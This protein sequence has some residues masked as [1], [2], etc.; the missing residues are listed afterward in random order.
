MKNLFTLTLLLAFLLLS[1]GLSAQTT[2]QGSLSDGDNGDP[3]IGASVT[4]KGTF[5]GTLTDNDGSF[6]LTTSKAPP[7][8]L[9]FSYAGY[10]MQE[11]QVV[12][13]AEKFDIR[14][15]PGLAME[16]VTVVGSRT[17]LR[18]NLEK[19]VP[20][21]LIG[22][23]QLQHSAQANVTQ[24]LQYTAPSFHSTPQTIS[25]GTDHIDPAALRGLGPDQTLVLINGKRRH[26]SSLLNV[27][28]TVG[29]G[30]VGT[31]LNSIPASAIDRI[32]VLRDGAAAQ[33]GSDA[34]AGVINIILKEKP[35]FASVNLQTGFS[36]PNAFGGPDGGNV[37]SELI[38]TYNNDGGMYQLS[39]NVGFGLGKNGGFLNATI[40]HSDRS[41][42]NRSG[43]YTGSIYPD[44][45]DN[46]KSEDAFFQQVRDEYDFADR[47]VMQI[48]NSAVT[49]TG[50]ML[51][52]NLPVN[53]KG[54]ELY[55]TLGLNIRNGLARGF[56]RFPSTQARVVPQIY[57]DGFSPAIDSD[58]NDQSVTVGLR[59]NIGEWK[60]D[61]SHTYGKNAFDFTIKNSINA[62]LGASSP[63]EAYAGGFSYAQNTSNVDFTREVEVG[64][65]LNIG[66]G[67]EFRNENYQIFNGEEASYVAGGVENEWPIDG[68]TSLVGGAAGIQVFPGFQPQNALDENRTNI[69]FYTELDFEFTDAFV[70]TTAGRFENYSDFGS[71]L[72]W[73]LASRYKLSSQYGVRGSISTGFRAPSLHQVYFNNLSTQFI[74]DPLTGD[75]VPVQVGTF[76]N[77]S[78]V[79]K[80]FGIADLKAETS[81]NYS[82]GFTGRVNDNF[83]FTIDGYIIDIKDRI[84]ISGRFSPDEQL[85][86][87]TFARDI[88]TP[89]GAGAAQFFTNAVSTRTKGLD[90]VGSYR[91]P[92]DN[93]DLTLTFAGNFTDT[94]VD[95]KDGVPVINTPPLLEGKENVLFNREEV[96]RIE[97]AQPNSK[98]SLSGLY[99]IGKFSA[100]LRLTRFGKITYIH[101]ADGGDPSE[102]PT[103]SF[104]GE[105][106]SRDQVFGAKIVPDLEVAYKI[107]DNVQ[108]TLGAHNFTNTY[109]DMHQHSSNVSSG[110]FLFSRRVQQFGVRGMFLYTK[111]GLTF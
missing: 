105:K 17:R 59:S 82:L 9:E 53:D 76:N 52:A 107:T 101:P 4:I 80:A 65:P 84:V 37:P 102:Y 3:L 92:T 56:Y 62:S 94:E 13:T 63:T 21:D 7:F 58:V 100:L 6:E 103:N 57:P 15:N 69:G 61:F 41:A 68:G 40:E 55:S 46:A 35:N 36:L 8:T 27:N 67:A 48:G 39:G 22:Q 85:A 64:F 60:A 50:I 43:N 91:I 78:K 5:I 54:T 12:S 16:Q 34:I 95:K 89:L 93:G 106:E 111:V 33:Y 25:D 86:D 73:K 20:V 29:R 99:E 77:G 49:N 30:T 51:N 42:T 87:S 74:A 71:N 104:T 32:E 44:G 81:T 109:P 70:V 19:A 38:P 31:D 14:L 72:S 26:A 47:Q 24:I 18:T 2:I 90:I 96:S 110:R 11:L 98:I 79:A 23:K 88:L 66:I 28:G 75:Q 10:N 1:I 83:A 97:V 45:Y 108:W